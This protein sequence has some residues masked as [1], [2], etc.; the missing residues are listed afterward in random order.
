[1]RSEVDIGDIGARRKNSV[2]ASIRESSKS[3]VLTRVGAC[4]TAS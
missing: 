1:M 4:G 2:R 3:W